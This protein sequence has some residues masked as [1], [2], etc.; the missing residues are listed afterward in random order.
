ME[1]DDVTIREQNFHS[2][3][4]EYIICFLLF[5]VLYIVSYF[6][7]TRYKRK[8]DDHEDE[9]AVVNRI[10]LYL[11]TFTL[12]VSGGAVSLLPFSIISN[13]ILLS[14]PQNYYIQWLNGSLIHGLWN[15]VSLFSNLCLFVLMPFA[16]FFLESEGFAGSKKGIKARILETFVML[17]LLA[18]LILGIVWVASALIDNDAASMESLYDLWEFYLPY[19]YSCISLMGGLLLLMC[20]PVGLSRM[21]T[22][23]GQLLVKPTILEDLDEQIYCIHLQEETLQRRLNGSSTHAYTRGS[24]AH[25]LNK[26]LDNIR[27]QRNKLERRKKASGWEKNLLYPIVMLILLTGTTISVLLVALNILYLLVDETAMPKGSTDRAIGNTSLSTFGVAQAVLEIVLI[28]YLMVSS[29]VGFYSLRVFEGLTPRKDDTTMTTI[30]GCCVS[31]LVLSSALPVMS[32]TLGITRFDLLGDF[33]RFNWLGNF[34]IVLSYNLLFAVVTTLCLVRKFTSA[35]REE[36]LK[37][38]GLD[39]LQ[40]SNS[41][42]DPESGKLSANGHQKTL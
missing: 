11:C 14:F 32:R 16:Y 20:T 18:L 28:F 4:R 39:K 19:L 6:I 29:V 12:A 10:S 30:I 15:L 7:I 26:E 17:F 31:I 37:A 22:V 24:F 3:V 41:P 42:T 1:E 27:N 2:Q 35:V 21:F 9:D 5:A 23:M 40:L 25:Q 33:G 8:S 34:Y 38:L 36:L 13:E